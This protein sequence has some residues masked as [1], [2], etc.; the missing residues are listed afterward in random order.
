MIDPGLYTEAISASAIHAKG[1]W[2]KSIATRF[3][4]LLVGLGPALL[5]CGSLA[6]AADGSAKRPNVLLIVCDDL[7]DW[8]LHPQGHP[9]A[10]TPNMDRLGLRSVNFNNAHVV[11]PVCGPS[12]KCL[13]SGLYPQTLNDYGFAPWRS[14]RSLDGCVPLPLHFRNNGYNAYG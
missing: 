5:A 10:K 4:A 11:V 7:N 14:V 2:V 8:V 3:V 12:R 6:G 1:Q 9:K 13:F